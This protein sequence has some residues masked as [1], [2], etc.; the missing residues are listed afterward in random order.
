M[1]LALD[2]ATPPGKVPSGGRLTVRKVRPRLL[3]STVVKA[4]S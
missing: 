3:Y 1:E 4:R 2:L